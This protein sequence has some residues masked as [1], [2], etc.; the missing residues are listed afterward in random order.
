MISSTIRSKEHI[1]QRKSHRRF[2]AHH[3]HVPSD[4]NDLMI[5]AIND[6]KLTWK[7]DTCKFQKHHVNYGSHCQKEAAL[8]LAQTK[9]KADEETEASSFGQQ[10]NFAAAWDE[11][12]KYQKYNSAEDIPE[13]ELPANFDWRNVGGVNFTSKHRDQGHCGS[14]YTVSFTQIV[15][16]RLR[17]K[18]GKDMPMLSPQYMMTCNYMNEG[19]DGGWP[20]FHGFLAENGHMV[21]EECAP[22]KGKTKGDKCSNYEQCPAHSKIEKTRFVGKGYGDT[23]EKKMMQEIIRNGMVNGELN[24]PHI[25]HMY[26][27]G[28]LTADGIKELHKKVTSLA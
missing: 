19:C 8:A 2:N 16:Q 18:Y 10:D 11:A 21:T 24:A 28:V 12:R 6:L 20:F 14:C 22:Y 25:F 7:A 23:S 15:E 26:T 9:A 17:L 13:A 3:A 1:F 4:E 5:Q 27:K